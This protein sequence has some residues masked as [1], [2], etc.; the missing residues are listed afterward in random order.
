M[1]QLAALTVARPLIED[2]ITRNFSG[3]IFGIFGE[4]CNIIDAHSKV[5]ALSSTKIPKGPFSIIVEGV[6]HL[7]S[8]LQLHQSAHIKDNQLMIGAWCIKLETAQV[9]EPKIRWPAKRYTPSRM[10][11]KCLEP[12]TEWPK[13]PIDTA[14]RR[15]VNQI[16]HQAA[17]NLQRA[18]KYNQS[19]ELYVSQ[20]AGLGSGLTPA[21]DDYLLGVI[22]ALW[23]I[24]DSERPQE[25]ASIAASKTM[26]LSAAFLRAARDGEFIEPWHMLT[27]ALTLESE[28]AIH[29]AINTITQF[30][31]S[32]GA[33]ALAGF[34]GVLL[35][36]K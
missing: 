36:N 5:I 35:S 25:I 9:W 3:Q 23:L 31:A 1:P 12:W 24:S 19:I 13:F 26:S 6:P 4:V 34:A 32:S 17:N 18:L 30:G 11:I 7:F 15:S 28:G 10:V 20:L 8:S 16:A 22:A 27:Q 2:G 14:V 21:G 29:Q 33:D